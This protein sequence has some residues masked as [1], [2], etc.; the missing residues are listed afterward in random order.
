MSTDL[1]ATTAPASAGP[2]KGPKQRSG[3]LAADAWH[4]LIRDPVFL[5][6]SAM[7]LVVLSWAVVPQL[8]T[9]AGSDGGRCELAQQPATPQLGAHL[10]DH[11][12]GL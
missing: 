8:W 6:S 4:E 2:A 12:P 9:S 7:V 3:S 11:G 5:I 1:G 10:R